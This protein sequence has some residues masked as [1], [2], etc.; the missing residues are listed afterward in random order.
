MNLVWRGPASDPSGY[1]DGARAWLRGLVANGAAV[2]LE[3][4]V[5]SY[6][7]AVTAAE[8]EWLLD[9]TQTPLPRVDAGIQNT[10]A[11]MLDPYAPGRVRIARTMF[12]T[13]RIPR[14]WVARCNQM[15]EVWVPTEHNRA[16]FAR[17]GVDPSR[18]H[19]IPEPFELERFLAP[20]EPLPIPEAHGTVVLASL[21]WTLRKGWDVLLTAWCRAFAPDDDVTLVVKAWSTSRGL[22]TPQIQEEAVAHIVRAGFDPGRMPDVVILDRLLPARDMPSLYAACDAVCLPTRGE[23]WGRPLTEAMAAGRPVIATAW[24]GPGEFVDAAVGWP[25]GYREV[26]VPDEA[27]AEVAAYAGHRWAEPDVDDL[28]AALRA[29]H[30]DRDGARA[31]GAA[32]R[33][34]AQAFDHRH[35]ARLA[36]E[37]LATVEPRARGTRRSTRR[38]GVVLEGPILREH[39]LSGVNRELAR[40]LMRAGDVELSLVDTQGAVLDADADPAIAPLLDALD[41]LLP[42]DPDVTLRH[43][44]PPVFGRPAS[45]RL[46]MMLNWEYGPAPLDWVR[47]IE[48]GIDEL[49]VATEHVRA[50]FE[51]SG[52]DPA[53]IVRLPH[54]VDPDRFRPGLD[55]LDLGGHAPGY[56]FLFVGGLIWRKGPDILFDA[57]ERAFTRDDDVTLVVKDFSPTGPY[58]LQD[59]AARLEELARNPRAGR[60]AHVTGVLAERDM[61]RLYAACDCLVHPY[62]GE[63]YGLPMAEAMACGLP[64]IV[65]DR[66]ACRDFAGPDT[67][68]L[69]PSREIELPGM[70]IGGMMLADRPR[71]VEI[72]VDD[73]AEAMRRAYD[74]RDDAAAVGA[75][76]CAHMHAGHTWDHTA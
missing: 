14:D 37:R 2:R 28:V 66:G 20:A 11:R 40:A 24:S 25:L 51:A 4:Q 41:E 5:W 75:R 55:P 46:A 33:E 69:V 57:Y 67:A 47:A 19:V 38:P 65:P 63:G 32:A 17:S 53:R 56:R 22:T 12:E 70:E 62:R 59:A 10:F 76:A 35:V 1:A 49:W 72:E 7:E 29:L 39:S 68:L 52:I 45:G 30:A 34:R 43:A 58:R 27:V 16:A 42:G 48:D 73:L 21:D 8:C 71:M 9:L 13:D 74:R 3:P 15:D 26:P 31:K 54:G 18:L 50:G 23:G 44:Y 64:V 36:L 61:P 6:R 60:V